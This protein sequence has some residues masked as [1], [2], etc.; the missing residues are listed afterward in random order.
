[1]LFF[2]SKVEKFSGCFSCMLDFLKSFCSSV[3]IGM[4]R[5]KHGVHE[6]V[7][8]I[9]IINHFPVLTSSDLRS[10]EA[11]PGVSISQ[12]ENTTTAH[13]SP[14]WKWVSIFVLNLFCKKLLF[15]LWK[16]HINEGAK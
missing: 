8:G 3:C 2:C 12:R 6:H 16:G 4:G 11:I 9:P 10:R 15:R 7:W 1:M 14:F 5:V 13:D